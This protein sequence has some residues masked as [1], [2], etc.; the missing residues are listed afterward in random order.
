MLAPYSTQGPRATCSP[1][2]LPAKIASVSVIPSSSK[3]S[4]GKTARWLPMPTALSRCSR[5]SWWSI[6]K[7]TFGPGGGTVTS[8][9]WSFGLSV[10]RKSPAARVA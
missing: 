5:T 3:V 10:S 6:V 2:A 9:T 1:N 4:I 7:S 8:A